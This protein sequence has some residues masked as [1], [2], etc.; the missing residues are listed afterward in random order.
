MKVS[1]VTPIH[2]EFANIPELVARIEKTME[3]WRSAHPGRD[4]EHLACDDHSTD[5]SLQLLKTLVAR[6]PRLRPVLNRMRSGQ[7]GGFQTGFD[8]AG[9]NV[10]VT[11]DADL[12]NLPEEIPLLI[13]PLEEGRLDLCNAIRTKRQHSGW[14]IAISKLGN[15]LIQ[16]LMVCPVS[17]AASNFTAL[18][19]SFT[20][21]L[22]LI[23]NDHRYLIPILVRRGMDPQRVGEISTRHEGRRHGA[24]K[25]GALRKAFTGL[26]E[27][28]RCKKRLE[29]GFYDGAAQ[30]C[31]VHAEAATS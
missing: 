3:A 31:H 14:L 4:W 17:D 20:R 6:H 24:S 27:L 22:K 30:A 23:E 7:T 18:R 10:I 1:V 29:A 12:Q 26:P 25:Y 19:A 8:H 9:G 28:L 21:D 5:G 2:N 11:M 15:V 16:W 13:A